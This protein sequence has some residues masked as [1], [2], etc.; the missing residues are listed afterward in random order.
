MP[1]ID[2]VKCTGCGIC[3]EECPAGVIWMESEKAVINMEGCIRCGICHD[4]CPSEA[5]RH[6]SE[7]IPD[8]VIDNVEKTK[9]SIDACAK[10]LGEEEKW[11]CLERIIRSLNREKIIADKTLIE[12]RKL[13]K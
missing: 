2:G 12:L 6:D 8:I 5:V 11:K 9:K 3:I 4:V 7:K 10:Y 13:K 1:W